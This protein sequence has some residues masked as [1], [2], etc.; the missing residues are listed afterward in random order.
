MSGTDTAYG[1]TRE[2]PAI[3]EI[4]SPGQSTCEAVKS[5]GLGLRTWGL[6]L[7]LSKIWAVEARP[8]QFQQ[9]LGSLT[10]GDAWCGTREAVLGLQPKPDRLHGPA[11]RDQLCARAPEPPH[12]L[13]P[14]AH[15]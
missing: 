3:G 5:Y 1:A 9:D 14:H 15:E 12:A 8:G 6:G 2:M 11:R 13:Q 10:D 7:G 4:V